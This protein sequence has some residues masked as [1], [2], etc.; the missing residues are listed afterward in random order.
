MPIGAAAGRSVSVGV[1]VPAG[2]ATIPA[3]P[4][5]AAGSNPLRRESTRP[6]GEGDAVCPGTRRLPNVSSSPGNVP[7][8]G[9]RSPLPVTFRPPIR[10]PEGTARDADPA[11]VCAPTSPLTAGSG[12]RRAGER[13]AA[14]GVI[15]ICAITRRVMTGE[16]FRVSAA[17]SRVSAPP[18]GVWFT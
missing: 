13:C 7:I 10:P 17:D 12:L 3:A 15:G 5:P 2:A 14:S 9:K 1:G 16:S 4:V 8:A 6:N 18:G 11:P